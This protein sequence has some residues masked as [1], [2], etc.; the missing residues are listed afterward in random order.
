MISQGLGDSFQPTR[1]MLVEQQPVSINGFNYALP[2]YYSDKYVRQ[3]LKDNQEFVV[4]KPDLSDCD[5]RAPS[6]LIRDN[7]TKRIAIPCFFDVSNVR[8]SENI[9]S[10]Y[11]RK[12]NHDLFDDSFYYAPM[13]F[14]KTCYTYSGRPYLRQVMPKQSEVST[15]AADRKKFFDSI[16]QIENLYLSLPDILRFSCNYDV[17]KLLHDVPKLLHDDEFLVF[18]Q[19]GSDMLAELKELSQ[20]ASEWR[21]KSRIAKRETKRLLKSQLNV[22]YSKKPLSW[23]EYRVKSQYFNLHFNH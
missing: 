21:A 15:L 20:I 9:L 2:R 4:H 17:P 22:P 12:C 11:R 19:Y 23:A 10:K 16:D 18:T 1:K 7:G 3:E 13:P 8:P 14:Y 5:F 6:F